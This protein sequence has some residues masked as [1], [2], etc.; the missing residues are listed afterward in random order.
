MSNEQLGI[1]DLNCM[2]DASLW[3]TS[4]LLEDEGHGFVKK[5][6]QIEAYSSILKLVE[7]FFSILSQVFLSNKYLKT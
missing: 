6:N 2:E 1:N 5:E 4:L 3:L 7:S